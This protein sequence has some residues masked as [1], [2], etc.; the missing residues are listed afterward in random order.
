M[1][2]V[3]LHVAQ[4]TRYSSVRSSA[5]LIRQFDIAERVE[6][7]RHLDIS[8]CF[9]VIICGLSGAISKTSVYAYVVT[10]VHHTKWLADSTI[11]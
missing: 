6:E 4:M 2:S 3:S 9:L 11:L 7:E 5:R 1:L 10:V 8:H